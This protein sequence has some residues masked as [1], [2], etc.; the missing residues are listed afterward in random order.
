MAEETNKAPQEEKEKN[1][2]RFLGQVGREM[3]RVTWPTR[4]ELMKYTGVVILTVFFIS[5]FFAIVDLGFS[6]LVRTFL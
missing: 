2:I 6:Y 4:Q 3:K 5:V 1:P